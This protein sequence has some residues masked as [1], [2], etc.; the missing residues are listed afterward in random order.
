MFAIR[1]SDELDTFLSD[2]SVN[3]ELLEKSLDF[4]PETIDRMEFMAVMSDNKTEKGLA[5][6]ALYQLAAKMDKIR[7]QE[8]YTKNKTIRY[9]QAKAWMAFEL[10]HL[11]LKGIHSSTILWLNDVFDNWTAEEIRSSSDHVKAFLSEYLEIYTNSKMADAS[12]EKG[13]VMDILQDLAIEFDLI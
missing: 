8:R 13:T 11:K 12:M 1:Y 9:D 7:E 10:T 4:M 6:Y 3:I 5:L 2:N